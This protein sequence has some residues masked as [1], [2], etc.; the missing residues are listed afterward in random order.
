MVS[1]KR[2]LLITLGVLLLALPLRAQFQPGDLVVETGFD[3]AIPFCDNH[4]RVYGPNGVFKTQ[5]TLRPSMLDQTTLGSDL[6]DNNGSFYWTDGRILYLID[7]AGALHALTAPSA[8][9]YRS[10]VV[11]PAGDIL[12]A[13]DD[14]TIARFASNGN[15]LGTQNIGSYPGNIDLSVDQCTLFFTGQPLGP[16]TPNAI[17][18]FNVCSGHLLAPLATSIPM[19]GGSAL[20]RVRQDASMLAGNPNSGTYLLDASGATQRSYT[21]PWAYAL[22]LDRDGHSFWAGAGGT[23]QK[24]DINGAISTMIA[25]PNGENV[26]S[27]AV[28]GEPRAA[29]G[30]ASIPTLTPLAVALLALSLIAVALLQFPALKA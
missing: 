28:V 27:L 13:A 2:L 24:Y 10:L 4:L 22:A 25:L 7:P 5:I 9:F 11:T 14:G 26:V 12:A 6:V 15:L 8:A 18:R 23:V 19:F 21:G 29:N 30:S 3:C 20:L 17:G 16:H 1:S